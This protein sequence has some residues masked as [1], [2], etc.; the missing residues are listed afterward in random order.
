N[1]LAALTAF[2]LEALILSV[3]LFIYYYYEEDRSK[4]LAR[5]YAISPEDYVQQMIQSGFGSLSA[6]GMSIA[7]IICGS[8]LFVSTMS[9]MICSVFFGFIG[10]IAARWLT[11]LIIIKIRK[12]LSGDDKQ[13][14]V[15]FINPPGDDHDTVEFI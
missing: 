3:R 6:F 8:T 7:G 5:K 12:K 2:T 9:P 15:A 13:Q 14:N 1:A 11:G 4:N 10:Y